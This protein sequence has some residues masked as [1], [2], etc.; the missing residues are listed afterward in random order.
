MFLNVNIW[1]E[2]LMNQSGN[3]ESDRAVVC[4]VIENSQIK[5]RHNSKLHPKIIF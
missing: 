3:R 1:G 4:V 5:D 2:I